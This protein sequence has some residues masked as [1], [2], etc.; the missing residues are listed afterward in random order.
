MLNHVTSSLVLRLA[1]CDQIASYVSSDKTGKY[2]LVWSNKNTPRC[3]RVSALSLGHTL[4][5]I[6]WRPSSISEL[7]KL[8]SAL[9]SCRIKNVPGVVFRMSHIIHLYITVLY[10]TRY[11]LAPTTICIIGVFPKWN[12]NSG[13]LIN[14]WS[15]NWAQFEDPVSHMCLAGLW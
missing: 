2:S 10:S 11:H 1:D 12:R 4:T 7:T 6:C 14:H 13:N 8:D 3:V 15:M 9:D 5:W